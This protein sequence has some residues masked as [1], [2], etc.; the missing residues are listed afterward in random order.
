MPLAE[1]IQGGK[2]L[3]AV[4][5]DI[6]ARAVIAATPMHAPDPLPQ[7][8]LIPLTATTDLVITGVGKAPAAGAVARVLNAS[9][10]L[11]LSTG[12]AGTYGHLPLL[13]TIAATHSILADEGVATPTGFD[14]LTALGFAPS[15]HGLH[16][17]T[18]P[19][20]LEALRPHCTH[21]GPIATVSTCSGTDTLARAVSTRT[22][23]LAEAMEGAAVALV[24]ERLSVPFAEL[25]VISNTTGDR[26]NQTWRMREALSTLTSVIGSVLKG[27]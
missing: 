16:I 27:V 21:T 3:I 8:Q 2:L 14:D 15:P 5:A 6:E 13:A 11:V 1:L 9:H 23:A 7:W 12:I 18:D 22:G 19:R 26:P 4:A 10:K 17:P 25:R 24:A 20:A